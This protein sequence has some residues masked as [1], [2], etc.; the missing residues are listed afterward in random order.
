MNERA[1]DV[2]AKTVTFPGLEWPCPS[3]TVTVSTNGVTAATLG[4]VQVGL[5]EVIALKLPCGD[6]GDVWVQL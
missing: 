4:A 1:D 6:A 3:E 5:A 2:F